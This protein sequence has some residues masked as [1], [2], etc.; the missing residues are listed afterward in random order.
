MKAIGLEHP[1]LFNCPLNAVV[2]VSYNGFLNSPFT[3]VSYLPPANEVWGKVIFLLYV[4]LFTGGGGIPACLSGFERGLQAHTQGRSWGVWLGGLQAHTQRGSPG[5]HPGGS[6][7]PHPGGCVSQYALRRT[8][9]PL[10]LLPR[11][12]R[13]LLE[14]ILDTI[15]LLLR[16][17][18]YK[19]VNY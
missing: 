4:I 3:Y 2:V 12:A 16:S 8:P 17:T 19:R 14:C 15:L 10:G 1:S 5:Q 9:R 13:I 6:P 18:M 7:G 11:A